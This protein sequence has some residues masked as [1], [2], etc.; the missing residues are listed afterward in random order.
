MF[1]IREIWVSRYYL[2]LGMKNSYL[3]RILFYTSHGRSEFDHVYFNYS[4]SGIV[5][6]PKF[7]TDDV[8]LHCGFVTDSMHII[9]IYLRVYDLLNVQLVKQIIQHLE[10]AHQQIQPLFRQVQR[11][12]NLTRQEMHETCQSLLS[13]N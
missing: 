12:I 6:Y 2:V 10:N 5:F 13:K 3:V 1:Y 7:R 4:R 8:R 9:D 11:I